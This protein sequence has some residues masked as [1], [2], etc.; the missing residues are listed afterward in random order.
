MASTLPVAEDFFDGEGEGVASAGSALAGSGGA[1]GGWGDIGACNY[2]C[3]I[4]PFVFLRSPSYDP[5]PSLASGI[6]ASVILRGH[7]HMLTLRGGAVN[8]TYDLH[9]N[10]Y[11]YLFLLTTFGPIYS[12]PPVIAESSLFPSPPPPTANYG[13]RAL[14]FYSLWGFRRFLPASTQTESCSKCR[15]MV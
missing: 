15:L 1:L 7:C 6:S 5:A 13:T 12:D 4:L 2:S 14:R 10:L 11:V 3:G 8:R 9:K